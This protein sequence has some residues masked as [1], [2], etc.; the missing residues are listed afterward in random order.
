[1]SELSA[2]PLTSVVVLARSAGEEAPPE[3]RLEPLKRSALPV[4]AHALSLPSTPARADARLA[5]YRDLLADAPAL[6]LVADARETPARLAEL[7][8]SACVREVVAA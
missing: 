5:L 7:V 4:L 1:C 8:R 2:Q 3:P 6:R